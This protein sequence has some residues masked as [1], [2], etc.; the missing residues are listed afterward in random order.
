VTP[1]FLDTGF[2]IALESADDQ[3][4]PAAIRFWQ[5]FQSDDSVPLVTTSYVLDEVATF[6]NARGFHAKAME[7]CGGLMNSPSVLLVH[8]D[9]DLFHES[10]RYFSRHRD[11]RYSLT[12][13]VSFVVMKRMKL[14]SALTFDQHF[15]QAGFERKP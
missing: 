7:A 2:V 12:D 4:H 15:V 8:V 10:W 9:E 14:K 6:F 3:N 1:I 11:K 5:E 13:C